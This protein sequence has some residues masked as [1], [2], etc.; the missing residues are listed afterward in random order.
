MFYKY[1]FVRYCLKYCVKQVDVLKSKRKLLD[2]TR[3]VTEN[4]LRGKTIPG[5][6]KGNLENRGWPHFEEVFMVSAL[7]GKIPHFLK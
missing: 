3:L 5:K 7:T 6:F 2:L 1:G 4:C